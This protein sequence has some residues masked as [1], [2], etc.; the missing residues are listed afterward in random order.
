MRK[1]MDMLKN[2]VVEKPNLYR[3]GTH[4]PWTEGGMKEHTNEMK[5]QMVLLKTQNEMR[6]PTDM[7]RVTSAPTPAIKTMEMSERIT[8]PG[9]A[10]DSKTKVQSENITKRT[11]ET[12]TVILDIDCK[13]VYNESNTNFAYRSDRTNR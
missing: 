11:I 10:M 2:E 7:L 3:P 9:N 8:P 1:Q 13:P 12:D 6:K 5:K 4:S